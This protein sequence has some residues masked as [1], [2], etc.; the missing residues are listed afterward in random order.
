MDNKIKTGLLVTATALFLAGCSAQETQKVEANVG[1]VGIN[2]CK[3]QGACFT[4]D[5]P[6]KGHNKCKGLGMTKVASNADCTTQGGNVIEL[7]SSH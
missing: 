6:C 2:A 5:N 7:T 1:C 3:G 4:A